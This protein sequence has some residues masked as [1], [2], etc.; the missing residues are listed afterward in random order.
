[1]TLTAALTSGNSAALKLVK[2]LLT[3]PA[4]IGMTDEIDTEGKASEIFKKTNLK[5]MPFYIPIEVEQHSQDGQAEVSENLIITTGDDRKKYL[6]D[7]IAPGPWTWTLNGYIPGNDLIEKTNKFTP[8]VNL[9]RDII[10]RAFKQGLRM[11]YKDVD[12]R[13]YKNVVIESLSIETQPDCQNKTP[14]SITLKEIEVIQAAEASMTTTE[15]ASTIPAGDA[16]GTAAEMG[17]TTTSNLTQSEGSKI[18]GKF[19]IDTSK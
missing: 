11:I 16:G 8:I 12:C 18:L 10:K 17:T 14:V 13:F 19:G 5:G 15:A 3:M 6:T 9:H 2:S 4:L 7:N 1:M